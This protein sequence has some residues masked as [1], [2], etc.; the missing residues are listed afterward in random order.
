MGQVEKF[1]EPKPYKY[2]MIPIYYIIDDCGCY[3]CIS[4]SK[5]RD[6]YIKLCRDGKFYR[7]HR[8]SYLITKG[9]IPKGLLIRHLCNNK[10]CINPDHLEIGTHREN[11]QDWK[12]SGQT[13][14]ETIHLSNELKEELYNSNCTIEELAKIYN[15]SH[16]TIIKTRAKFRDQ[17]KVKRS[18]DKPSIASDKTKRKKAIK[19]SSK[20]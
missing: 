4:H 17:V 3:N 1:V 12:K 8:Y 10:S 20:I 16:T 14:K 5:D 13:K 18:K 7:A 11:Y 2:R 9:E 15:V 6:G 19:A